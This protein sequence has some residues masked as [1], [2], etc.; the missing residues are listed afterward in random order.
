LSRKAEKKF[1]FYIAGIRLDVAKTK[2]KP[3]AWENEHKK[4]L[5][6][7]KVERLHSFLRNLCIG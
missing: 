3:Q 2:Q 7:Q 5:E 6:R 4:I 1:E